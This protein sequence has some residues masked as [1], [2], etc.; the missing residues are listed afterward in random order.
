ML[1]DDLI[2]QTHS[3]GFSRE[4]PSSISTL[5]SIDLSLKFIDFFLYLL[6]LMSWLVEQD[7]DCIV[8]CLCL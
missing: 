6:L 4:N 1:T 8:F 2:K 3:K 5:S 7:E